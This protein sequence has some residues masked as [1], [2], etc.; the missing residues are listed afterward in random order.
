VNTGTADADEN[1]HPPA[2]YLL[3]GAVVE[4]EQMGSGDGDGGRGG[5]EWRQWIQEGVV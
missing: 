5:A 3:P 4:T 2:V 1:Y